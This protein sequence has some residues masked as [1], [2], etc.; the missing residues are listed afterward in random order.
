MPYCPHINTLRGCEIGEVMHQA[1]NAIGIVRGTSSDEVQG[2][3][4]TLVERWRPACRLAG[5]IAKH[6]G[7]ADRACS[8]GFLRSVTSGERF[9]I[10]H[11][12]GP[13]SAECHLDGTEALSAANAVQRDIAAGCDLVVLSKFGKPEAS[14]NGLFGAF[15]AALQT[16]IPLLTSVSPAYEKQWE[17]L[18]GGLYVVLP[19]DLDRISAWRQSIAKASG[20]SV[21]AAH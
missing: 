10:F 21:E 7:L 4:Q 18:A 1:A 11:D 20:A 15:K 9:S 13:G 19:A 14:G 3:F 17:E 16:Q 12:L 6:H 8:A 2:I 5:L